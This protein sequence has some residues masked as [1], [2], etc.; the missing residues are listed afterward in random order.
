VGIQNLFIQVEEKLIQWF[1]YA[2]IVIFSDECVTLCMGGPHTCT[3]PHNVRTVVVC[4]HIS[5]SSSVFGWVSACVWFCTSWFIDAWPYVLSVAHCSGVSKMC[6]DISVWQLHQIIH[7]VRNSLV[8]FIFSL[9]NCTISI[10]PSDL[11]SVLMY[12][13]LILWIILRVFWKNL[14][15]LL[16]M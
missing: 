1:G 7:L 13:N 2:E 14:S 10:E 6:R 15:K 9:P 11:L 4:H 5:V 16:C 12:K 3:L 8:I